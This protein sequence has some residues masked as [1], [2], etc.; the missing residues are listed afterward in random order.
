LHYP[1]LELFNKTMPILFFT[2]V[3]DLIGFGLI[4]PIL[5]FITPNFGGS[6]FDIAL[7]IACYSICAGICGP[8]WGKLSDRY[9]RKPVLLTC[10]AGGSI[11]YLIMAFSTNLEMLYASRIAAGI[12]AG[13]FGVA[14]AMVADM[15]SAQN[16][17]KGM[18]MIGAAFGI[19][20]VIGPFIGGFLSGDAADHYL[21]G[22]VASALSLTA[23]FAG[24]CFLKESLP[25]EKRQEQRKQLQQQNKQSIFAMLKNTGNSLLVFQYFL[26]NSC[27]SLSTYL[28]PL[29]VAARLNWGP[30]ETGLT[31]GAVGLI[32]IV[33][34][35][36]MIGPMIKRFNE[37]PLLFICV[38]LMFIGFIFSSFAQGQEQMIGAF[39]I[40]LTGAT[41][42]IP[43]LSSLLSKR[44]P[45][46][47]RGRMMGTSTA[48]SAWGRTFGPI[49]AGC[50]LG[51]SGFDLS[52]LMGALL[53]CFYLSWIISQL[54][55]PTPIIE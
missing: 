40:T 33:V 6:H 45:L 18:G 48:A 24:A 8:F 17:A 43:I 26:H 21:P 44:T 34:Q 11:S 50:I 28:F 25:P 22:L 2:V 37:L 4:I 55:K 14:S 39:F 29:W 52:W 23:L 36:R 47:I 32:M 12:M 42:C 46:E 13:N 19:G 3:I 54:R 38:S 7:L 31:F 27:V 16:R 53:C 51:I 9:G 35:G 30:K 15:T 20:L 10:L 5:P 41:C 49:L 1:P